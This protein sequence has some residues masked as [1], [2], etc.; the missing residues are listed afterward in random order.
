MTGSQMQMVAINWHVYVLT[1]SP[2]AI[3]TVG[4]V[5][6]VP[7][8][9]CSLIGGVVADA[10]DRKRLIVA[11]Q[12]VM[13]TSAGVLA[14]VTAGGLR[15][16]W[17]IYLL[18]AVASAAIAFENPAR[19]ALLPSLVP[20][21]HFPNAVSLGMISFHVAT[22][23]GPV[24]AGLLLA[25]FGPSIVYLINA[26]SFIAV[27]VAVFRVRAS[28]RAEVDE[29]R[30]ANQ[31][32]FAALRDGLKF[33]WRTPIIV[34]TMTLDFAATFFASATALLPIF[35]AEILHV[36]ASG[37]GILASSQAVGSVMAALLM[38]RL[39]TFSH[40]GKTV[41]TAIGVYA[42]ATIGFGLSKTFGFSLVMLALIGAS[43]TV[44]TVLRQTIRQLVTPDSLR[45]RMT[46]VNMMFFMGGP[47]LG[48][49]EAGAL[50]R[51]IGAPL[52]VVL[53]GA[54][55]LAAVLLALVKARTLLTYEGSDPKLSPAERLR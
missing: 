17:P 12:L 51:F 45:G 41:I 13:L 52:S 33:V 14:A 55:C 28:G 30:A 40:Q 54:G 22:I 11:T 42:L 16:V 23:C 2:L 31:I 47:Q 20:P 1:R 46:S 53:G 25:R 36:G 38:A 49:F 44:S 27:I 26:V 32:S 50:A 9:L 3:G 8:I 15:A 29:S 48:E 10:T 18:T 21:E 19:Q 7:I 34:E 5:R 4:L 6:V 39:G 35:A 43:D 37:F 24:A